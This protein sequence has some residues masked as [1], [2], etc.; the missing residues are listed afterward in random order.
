MLLPDHAVAQWHPI[1][2]ENNVLAAL[3]EDN[4]VLLQI[5]V[6]APTETGMD[7]PVLAV[8]QDKLGTQLH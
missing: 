3:E 6:F 4:G 2:M 5:L 1:G 7:T 8:L